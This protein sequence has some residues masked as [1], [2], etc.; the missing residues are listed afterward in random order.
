[1]RP[2]IG[3][4][5]YGGYRTRT[6]S[7]DGSG[8]R[9]L[10][11]H[12]YTDSADTWNDVLL[13][14]AIAGRSAMAVDL[15]GF[16][17][18]D[19]LSPHP[20]LPQLDQDQSR[21]GEVVLVGNSLGGCLSVRAA[22]R[23]APLAGA[24][25][26]GDPAGGKWRLRSWAGAART[27][28]LLGLAALPLPIP[29]TVFRH[30]AVP[31]LGWLVYADRRVAD[32]AVLT[33]FADF[34]HG[35]GGLGWLVRDMAALASEL[36]DGHNHMELDCPLLIVHGRK[37]RIV[38]LAASR[39][40]RAAVPGSRLVVEPTWGHCPQ[41]DDRR[42]SPI[43]SRHRDGLGPA[44]PGR[45]PCLTL[46]RDARRTL[47]PIQAVASYRV[48]GQAREAPPRRTSR[49]GA[50]RS[51]FWMIAA[52]APRAA[53]HE[54]ARPGARRSAIPVCRWPTI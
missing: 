23:G 50:Q 21:R 40:L 14:L 4:A 2:R 53:D 30:A 1:M 41:L 34:V 32:R 13:E 36:V 28:W 5:R 45:G 9:L 48:V 51:L 33:R 37:D 12:G 10:L 8:P 20:M 46:S 31:L 27:S 44:L 39:A 22:A 43:A 25:T 11:L 35:Q 26:I 19:N 15:P 16:G 29:A 24:V 42:A 49:F 17:R 6:L 3:T 18:A 47:P 52:A 54:S 7:V 38:P